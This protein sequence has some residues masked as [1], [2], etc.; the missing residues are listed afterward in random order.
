MDGPDRSPEEKAGPKV[1]VDLD[2]V[3]L[4]GVIDRSITGAKSDDLS[5]RSLDGRAGPETGTDAVD[6]L[7]HVA[8][9]M[10]DQAPP[11]RIGAGEPRPQRSE[12]TRV[13]MFASE[14]IRD[15]TFSS[16]DK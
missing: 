6:G 12:M 4:W 5:R 11:V 10:V 13:P 9:V 2:V 7:N 8:N 1:A 16:K 14:D 15:L 3:W